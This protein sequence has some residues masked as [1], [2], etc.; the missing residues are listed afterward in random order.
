MYKILIMTAASVLIGCATYTKTVVRKDV[1]KSISQSG[2]VSTEYLVEIEIK[3]VHYR[4][5]NVSSKEFEKIMV[6]DTVAWY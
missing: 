4:Y 6:G 5:R 1:V 3:S 2:D